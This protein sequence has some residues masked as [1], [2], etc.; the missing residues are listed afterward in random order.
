M[1]PMVAAV[2]S[3]IVIIIPTPTGDA[4]AP[5]TAPDTSSSSAPVTSGVLGGGGTGVDLAGWKLTLPTGS[6]GRP[7]EVTHP[8]PDASADEHWFAQTPDH[9]VAFRAPV[10]GVTTSGSHNPRSELR[11]M[12]ADGSTPAAWSG[13]SGSHT[14]RLREAFTHL[15][16]GK[17]ELVGAQIHNAAEDISMFRLEGTNLYV[18]DDVEHAHK[19]QHYKLLTNNYAL[20]TPFDAA[21]VVSDGQIRAYYNNTLAASFAAPELTGAYFKAGAY[22]QANCT[23]SSPCSDDNYGETLI[24]Q[25]QVSHTDGSSSSADATATSR[26]PAKDSQ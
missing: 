20:G 6:K 9:A 23:N 25:L 13:G 15:P 1:I 4:A 10:N 11:E 18:T 2:L 19:Q 16:A 5:A 22:T 21:Y 8:R 14:M 12:S 7:T 3:V 17:P 24:Y 26:S